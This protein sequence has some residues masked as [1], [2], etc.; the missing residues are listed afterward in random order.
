MRK[1]T[2]WWMLLGTALLV[3]MTWAAQAGWQQVGQMDFTTD[4]FDLAIDSGDT[5]YVAYRTVQKASVMR[6]NGA[7][8][9]QVGA[10]GFSPGSA[11][12]ISFALDSSG[13]P[14]VAYQDSANGGKASV[15]RFNGTS[16]EQVGV[17]GFSPDSAED[18]QLALDSN[19]RPYVAFSYWDYANG[20]KASVMRFNGAS[21][22]QVGTAG[23][24]PDSAG[25]ISLALDSSGRPYVA[26][27]YWDS[28]NNR[29]KV[30]VM[31]FNGTSWEQVGAA[32]FSL[33]DEASGIQLALDSSG[34]PYIAY[35]DGYDDYGKASVMRFNG[36]NWEQVGAAGFS[37]GSSYNPSL[38]LDSNDRP[39]V[40]FRY[41]EGVSVMRFVPDIAITP[42][43]ELLLL[44]KKQ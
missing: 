7:S 5:P 36:T 37:P 2:Y 26:F 43:Y 18:I 25:D 44:K 10:A 14:Y 40:A 23:F 28:T 19:G 17:A 33:G 13:T 4:S 9:E 8:W 41:W 21:W 3:L 35:R 30:G 6:F 34:R 1:Q 24:S 22:E 11:Y 42:V 20:G 31:R 12:D 39:Y 38:A 15:M 32:G 29:S 16:W 27:S